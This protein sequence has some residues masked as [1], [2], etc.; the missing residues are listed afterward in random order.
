MNEQLTKQISAAF[1]CGAERTLAQDVEF[2]VDQLVEVAVRALSP[3]TNDPFTAIRC[4]DRLGAALCQL[5]ERVIPSPYRYDDTDRL[6]VITPPV[7]FAGVA[8]AAFDQIRQYGRTSAAV[9]IRLLER[10]AAIAT[11]TYR[12]E[13]RAVLLRHAVMIEQ[14][15]REGLPEE[16]DRQDV[17]ERFQAVVRALEQRRANG[18]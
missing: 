11:H 1:I 5:T 13:D 10:I 9:T 6:R 15:S 17:Q 16:Q 3:G 8:D 14:G 12:E 4:I 7:T 18:Q 2:A